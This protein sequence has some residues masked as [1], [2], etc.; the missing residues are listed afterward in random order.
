MRASFQIRGTWELGWC[1]QLDGRDESVPEFLGPAPKPA[2]SVWET[3]EVL[4]TLSALAPL[5]ESKESE[6][7]DIP[8]SMLHQLWLALFLG[9]GQARREYVTEE[10][11]GLRAS[12]NFLPPSEVKTVF[13][14]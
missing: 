13:V 12:I 10:N 7:N 3:S 1:Q 11:R 9:F 14:L 5:S 4:C 6:G 2:P 8:T